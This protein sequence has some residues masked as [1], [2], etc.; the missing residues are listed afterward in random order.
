MVLLVLASE[1]PRR[2]ALLAQAGIFPD[3]V[4][5]AT[6]DES[7]RKAELPRAHAVRLAAEKARKVEAEWNGNPAFILAADTVVAVGRRILP[8]AADDEEVRTCL[9]RLSGRRHK[10]ITAVA[11]ISPHGR[12][13]SRVAETRVSVQKLSDASIADYVESREGVGKAGGYAIQGRAEMLIKEISGS[14]SNVVGL[15]LAQTVSLLKG[16]GYG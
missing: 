11:L 16:A 2:L 8:K 7:V 12:L 10:V 14:W 3:A 6:I 4:L 5:P 9:K 13:R 15:P 1:S